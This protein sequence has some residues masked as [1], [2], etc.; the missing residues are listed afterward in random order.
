MSVPR[1]SQRDIA[2]LEFPGAED[3]GF[4]G[5][6]ERVSLETVRRVIPPVE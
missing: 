6:Y 2:E 5:E 1:Y 4:D 3:E